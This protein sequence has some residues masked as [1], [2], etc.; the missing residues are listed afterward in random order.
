MSIS[1]FLFRLKNVSKAS[2]G[3]IACCPAHDDHSPS[4]SVS[5]GADGRILI[6][7]HAGC[8]A[9]Q[10]VAAINLTMADLFPVS[11]DGFNFPAIAGKSARAA[12]YRARKPMR[13][14]S[15]HPYSKDG[16]L[17][18]GVFRFDPADG[19]H[20][21][22]YVPV[23]S[24]PDGGA[25]GDPPDG[26][27]LYRLEEIQARLDDP[28]FLVEGEKA[29]DAL[30]GL[31][32]LATTSAHGSNAWKK[33][34]WS[35]LAGRDLIAMPDNDDAGRKY[36]E[37]VIAHVYE[38]GK[39]KSLR[40]I[41]LSHLA[42][43]ADAFDL[44]AV[45]REEC[46]FDDQISDEIF[47]MAQEWEPVLSSAE[48]LSN[49]A[50]KPEPPEFAL[51]K[52]LAS[53]YG[54]PFGRSVKNRPLSV[55]QRFAAAWCTHSLDLIFDPTHNSFYEY[56]PKTGLWEQRTD[57][58]VAD[59]IGNEVG[60]LL[61]VLSAVHLLP[62]CGNSLSV[63]I[64]NILKGK[65]EKRD[66]WNKSENRIHLA[67]GMLKIGAGTTVRHL[68]GFS[69]EYY[70][71][72]R[73]AYSWDLYAQCP[74]FISELLEPALSAEDIILLQKYAG[75]CL[76]GRNASQTLLMIR[77]TAGGGKS[78]LCE[79]I[80]NV[81]GEENVTQLRVEQLTNRFE[82]QR[83]QG[84]T[85]LSGKDV[86]GNFLDS[87]G[88]YMLKSLVGGDRLEGEVKGGNLSFAI[89][90]EY[91]SIITSNSCLCVRLDGD[92]AAW[93]RRL[94][95]IDFDQ[96]P[97][98]KRIPFF[99]AR[100]LEEEGAGILRWMIDGA[101]ALLADLEQFGAIQLSETQT[102]RVEDLLSESDSIRAFVRDCIVKAD[103]CCD[104]TTSELTTAYFDYCDARG[105]EPRSR[106][107]FETSATDIMM[108]IHRASRRNDIERDG[109][110]HR[111]Y[112][113]VRFIDHP[114]GDGVES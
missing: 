67:N 47:S 20:G 8:S 14:T 2:G 101:I 17:H 83:F 11:K 24:T 65:L 6:K 103:S 32:L 23:H 87:K 71:R 34:D 9:Q 105:W 99:S 25:L 82:S 19:S 1:D 43:K 92:A 26:W 22:Q 110:K 30:A 21:K 114:Y 44:V 69:P 39:P 90:G 64:C 94:L 37:D 60:K 84:R 97:V 54:D 16:Q 112:S 56:E 108:E 88:A 70:S 36:I 98:E 35:P 33:T 77:G 73:S 46:V 49:M 10:V 102:K 106:R 13:E 93:R 80:E 75:Q 86:A 7:C 27:P 58:F 15:F 51:I 45:L 79:V 96:P 52:Q 68:S 42:A 53:I 50:E 48:G 81:I 4:L 28:V 91:N 59:Q 107:R 12:Q 61:S 38:L 55:N 63:A 40:R 18:A 85:L 29:A 3:W 74:R 100:L 72:N 41:E 76:L 109:T 5:E 104:I 66:V 95:I 111:G 78:T 57:A 113:N 62:K 31:G 89:R